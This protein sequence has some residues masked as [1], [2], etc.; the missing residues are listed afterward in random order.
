M[1]KIKLRRYITES[2]NLEIILENIDKYLSNNNNIGDKIG[3]TIG[4]IAMGGLTGGALSTYGNLTNK[5]KQYNALQQSLVNGDIG[6][7]DKSMLARIQYLNNLDNR[8]S[9]LYTNNKGHYFL[10]PFVVGPISHSIIKSSRDINNGVYKVFKNNKSPDA[11]N[12]VTVVADPNNP[13]NS[14]LDTIRN[15]SNNYADDI[16]D[17]RRTNPGH[18]YLNPFVA[19]PLNEF[20]AGH[21]GGALA[22]GIRV[23]TSHTSKS[24]D[25]LVHNTGR[26]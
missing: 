23:A 6:P 4:G 9:N 2:S 15:S 22:Q 11:V 14:G 16:A 12:K 25:T 26:R 10:N 3:S 20:V 18:Y 19:G 5:D 13:L 1:A 24:G 7:W 8:A 21:L 17:I